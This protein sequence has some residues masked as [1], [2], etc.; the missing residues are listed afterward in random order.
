MEEKVSIRINLQQ[1]EVELKGSESFIEKVQPTLMG[2]IDVMKDCMP[3]VPQL[4]L[5]ENSALAMNSALKGD[6]LSTHL[7]NEHSEVYERSSPSSASTAKHLS[8]KPKQLKSGANDADLNYQE[9]LF[10]TII[11]EGNGRITNVDVVLLAG[12][13]LQ[14]KSNY[15]Y[16]KTK[17]VTFLLKKISYG[18]SNP[19][20]FIK[21]NC[22][23]N[24]MIKTQNG[25]MLTQEGEKLLDHS[26]GTFIDLAH[27]KLSSH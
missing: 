4:P 20:H 10:A 24:R 13:I 3:V 22:D 27:Q 12:F 8:D 26:V 5:H 23:Y 21:L 7:S 18:I 11:Q 25:Y 2:L 9:K 6:T 14:D 1:S 15:N 19:S 16:F 17:D